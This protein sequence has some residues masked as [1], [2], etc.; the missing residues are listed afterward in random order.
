LGASGIHVGASV[1]TDLYTGVHT[2]IS[3]NL[4]YD[5]VNLIPY[6][7]V[8]R[9]TDGEGVI[10]DTNTNYTGGFEVTDNTTYGNSGAGIEDFYTSNAVITGNVLSGDLTNPL[11]TGNPEISLTDAPNTTV[12][13]NSTC[14]LTGTRIATPEGE[15]AVEHLSVGDLVLTLDGKV[16]PV[17]WIGTGLVQAA[18]G[19]RDAAT[20]VIVR[21]NALGPNV[22]NRDL[23]V[24][25]AHS[26]YID[27]LL[28]P[29]EFLVNHRSIQW[30]DHARQVRIFHIELE[31]H[32]VLLANGA[33]AESYRDDGNR[34]L[35]ENANTGWGLPPQE[36]CAPV[37]TGGP[38]VDAIWRR[39]L[40]R[41]GP[42]PGLPRTDDPDLHLLVDSQR[43]D[44]AEQSGEAC[45]F[46][47]PAVPSS[48]RIASRAAAPAELGTARDPRVL[49]VALRRIEVRTD[50]QV[51]MIEVRDRHLTDGFH[52]FESDNGF[53]WTDG[54]AVIPADLYA[55]L[56][57]P[58]EVTLRI[59]GTTHYVADQRVGM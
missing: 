23:R 36:P 45:V 11:I 48:L 56:T 28:I 27:N 17:V 43:L 51:R 33:P 1:D 50:T 7:P 21:K 14:F 39:L 8:G 4:S 22:P 49:G 19:R 2:I 16:R 53:R 10:L 12:S 47:L 41:A 20:P 44:V 58:V 31:T 25:K 32:D 42:R 55:G 29:V 3:G 13:D 40:D 54:D 18:P 15:I 57:G 5:N 37:L 46:H 24:T 9:I 59:G 30:D 6:Y 34:W 38:V 52:A 26:L 35:F